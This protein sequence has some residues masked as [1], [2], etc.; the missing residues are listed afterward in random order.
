[1]GDWIYYVTFLRMDQIENQI[2][3]A[4]EIHLGVTHFRK[5]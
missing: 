4:Q 2:H 5:E 1:M 3:I